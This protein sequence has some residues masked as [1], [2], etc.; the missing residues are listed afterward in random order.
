MKLRSLVLVFLWVLCASVVNAFA[1]DREAF[2]FT[3][4]DLNV[5]LE[6]ANSV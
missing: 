5:R 6:P 1:L 3:N 4:Y 2:T